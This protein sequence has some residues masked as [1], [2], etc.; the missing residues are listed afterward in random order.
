MFQRLG[1]FL[2]LDT[3]DNSFDT[4]LPFRE[5]PTA[6]VELIGTGSGVEGTCLENCFRIVRSSVWNVNTNRAR[7]GGRG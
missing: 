4:F 3:L 6:R 5:L 1:P 7:C 2:K